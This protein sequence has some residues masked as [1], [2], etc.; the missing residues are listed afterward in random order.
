MLVIEIRKVRSM[1]FVALYLGFGVF[2]WFCFFSLFFF[3]FFS[4]LTEHGHNL[5]LLKF[6]VKQLESKFVNSF[7]LVSD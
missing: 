2:F 6:T 1:C 3:F 5:V 7:C 4:G